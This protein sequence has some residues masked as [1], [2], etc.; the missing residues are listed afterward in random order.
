MAERVCLMSNENSFAQL[1]RQMVHE[2]IEARGI[3][4]PRVLAA[5]NAVPRHRFV[6]AGSVHRAYEDTP[7]SIGHGQTISQPYMVALMTELAC[8]GSVDRALEVGTGCGYQTAILCQLAR[9]VFS[10]E[11]VAALADTARERLKNL[12]YQNVE[13]RCGDGF[14]GWPE[15]APFD[16][17]LVAAAPKEIPNPLLR[18]LSLG[19]RLVIPVGG[20]D[21]NLWLVERSGPKEFRRTYIT[22]CRFVPMTGQAQAPPSATEDEP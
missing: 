12:G 20:E 17:I 9:Q 14:Q 21:Q 5:L 22:G 10:I 2:Q 18:Q 1:R 8:A 13:I 4:D 7:L 11:I 3:K 19:G 16:A 15:Q 6:P